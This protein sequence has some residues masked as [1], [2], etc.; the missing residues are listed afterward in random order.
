[1]D[2]SCGLPEDGL[3]RAGLERGRNGGLE[4][5]PR[6]DQLGG[7]LFDRLVHDPLGD[8]LAHVAVLER[9]GRAVRELALVE[10]RRAHIEREGAEEERDRR[11]YQEDAAGGEAHRAVSSLV[12][13]TSTT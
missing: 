2:V 13:R 10:D 6:L 12:L 8:D 11:E 7:A 4:K 3:E 5:R 9:G 1:M